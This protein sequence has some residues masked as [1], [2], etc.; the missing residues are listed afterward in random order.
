[1][2]KTKGG[3]VTSSDLWHNIGE[4]EVFKMTDAKD[5]A[6]YFL[7]KD[8]NR[9]IFTS[10]YIR[11]NGASFVIGSARLNKYLHMAQNMWI[12]KT[13]ELL[14][15]QPLL[16]FDNG[17]V[18][19]DIRLNYGSFAKNASAYTVQLSSEVRNFLDKL[20]MMLKNATIDELIDLSHQDNEWLTR[21]KYRTKKDQEMDPLSRKNEY[22]EQYADALIIL[23]HVIEDD[24]IIYIS[25]QQLRELNPA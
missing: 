10:E 5:I 8:E 12:A 16:A 18:V 23:E 17:A 21:N 7:K 14:F 19:E 15:S 3:I 6:K 9:E 4:S 24:K 11:R 1:V 2:G 20:Y 13:G 25:E 22:K